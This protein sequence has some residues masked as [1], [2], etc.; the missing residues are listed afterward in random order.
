MVRNVVHH[1]HLKAL[2]RGNKGDEQEEGDLTF[3]CLGSVSIPVVEGDPYTVMTALSSSQP[4]RTR[5]QT[6]RTTSVSTLS[7]PRSAAA[8]EKTLGILSTRPC[9]Q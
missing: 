5:S 8:A 1:I 7:R 2:K 9:Q 3:E 6:A 4:G